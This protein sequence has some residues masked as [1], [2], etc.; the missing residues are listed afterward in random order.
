MRGLGHP[1]YVNGRLLEEPVTISHV[2]GPVGNYYA[3]PAGVGD[4]D[5]S[6]GALGAYVSYRANLGAFGADEVL[7]G[8]SPASLPPAPAA[9]PGQAIFRL[10]GYVA[11]LSALACAYHGYKRNHSIGWALLWGL[12]GG[13]PITP[14]IA[15]AQGFG[16]PKSMTPNRSV[17]RRRGA[18][19][20]GAATRAAGRT[21]RWD[22]LRSGRTIGALDLPSWANLYEAKEEAQKLYGE[23]AYVATARRAANSRRRKARRK[24][25]KKSG[26][27]TARERIALAG[28]TAHERRADVVNTFNRDFYSGKLGDLGYSSDR[29]WKIYKAAYDRSRKGSR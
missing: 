10:W 3:V 8:A 17:S 12:F 25:P 24:N 20:R 22:V 5:P 19:R 29:A 23:D 6:M 1:L 14:V 18:A 15:L 9:P 2:P 21:V 27:L 28:K 11:P 4:V 7:P 13:M 16:K 26:A